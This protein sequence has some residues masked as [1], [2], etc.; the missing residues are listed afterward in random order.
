MQKTKTKNNNYEK[1]KLN[2]HLWNVVGTT[3]KHDN[4]EQDYTASINIAL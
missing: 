3:S 4:N 1:L 2:I